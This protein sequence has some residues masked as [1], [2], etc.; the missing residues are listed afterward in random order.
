MGISRA[1]A[2]RAMLAQNPNNPLARYGLAME[3]V[4]GGALDQ[5]IAE[6]RVL[7]ESKPDYVAAYFHAGQT[8]ER[9]G[10]L[11]DARAIYTKGIEVATR[12]GDSHTRSEI[13]G[14]LAL[15]PD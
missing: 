1:D 11:D 7:L 14:A 9:L 2:L 12:I 6:F 10:Q 8:F 3:L 15:L 4:N 5:G 13:E